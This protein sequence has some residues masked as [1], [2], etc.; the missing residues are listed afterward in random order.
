MCL[1]AASPVRLAQFAGWDVH[2]EQETE[3]GSLL[4]PASKS[5]VFEPA[6]R[7]LFGGSDIA[8]KHRWRLVP[9]VLTNA[10]TCHVL[11]G[12]EGGVA[13]SHAVTAES[14]AILSASAAVRPLALKC[15]R[16]R[17]FTMRETLR[18]VR[19]SATMTCS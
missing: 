8:H 3:R 18:S 16:T 5:H 10:I 12:R 17:A 1:L 14:A 4:L 13:R 7:P 6:L 19:R 9:R 2:R 15:L 11:G